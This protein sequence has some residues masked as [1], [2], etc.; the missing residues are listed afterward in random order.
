MAYGL[1]EYVPILTD[2]HFYAITGCTVHSTLIDY[3]FRVSS[4]IQNKNFGS[5]LLYLESGIQ[6]KAKANKSPKSKRG[7]EISTKRGKEIGSDKTDLDTNHEMWT[8]K[9]ASE[10]LF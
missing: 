4:T 1:S 3:R 6:V 5:K 8:P 7:K 9:V 2:K 10:F